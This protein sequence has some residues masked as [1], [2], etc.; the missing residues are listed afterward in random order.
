MPLT[1]VRI[2]SPRHVRIHAWRY[3]SRKIPEGIDV[4]TLSTCK[5]LMF[6]GETFEEENFEWA[7]RDIWTAIEKYDPSIIGY[8][9]DESNPR[10][11]LEHIG[12]R[13]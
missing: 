12:T 2:H 8:A 6:R 10:I 3:Y 5:Y 1:P 13:E 9:W 11:Q 7:T 4:I